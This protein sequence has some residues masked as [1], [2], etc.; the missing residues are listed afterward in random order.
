MWVACN[1]GTRSSGALELGARLARCASGRLTLAHVA[2]PGDE[3]ID[4]RQGL[5]LDLLG[6]GELARSRQRLTMLAWTAG[7]GIETDV[8]VTTGRV[9]TT[10]RALLHDH[11][12]DV[13]LVGSR[14]GA[15]ACSVPLPLGQALMIGAPCPVVLVPRRSAIASLAPAV[16]SCGSDAGAG[17]AATLGWRLVDLGSRAAGPDTEGL[18]RIGEACQVHRPALVV[19]D[20]G[21]GS[22]WR[23]LCGASRIDALLEVIS[24]PLLVIPGHRVIGCASIGRQSVGD[25]DL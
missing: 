3:P 23:M 25:G 6:A 10:M 9:V 5:E 17:V 22:G 19:T 12:P 2:A 21:L 4:E 16:L 24:S 7:A 20:H 14:S 8:C 1:H 11:R 13:V 18:R 15:G